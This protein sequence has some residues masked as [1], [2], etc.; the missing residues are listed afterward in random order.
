MEFWDKGPG[1]GLLLWTKTGYALYWFAGVAGYFWA[2]RL[3]LFISTSYALLPILEVHGFLCG[4]GVLLGPHVNRRKAS[5]L[6]RRNVPE[7]SIRGH[8]PQW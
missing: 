3:V 5:E 7:K 4:R 2:V 8:G 1:A 6:C